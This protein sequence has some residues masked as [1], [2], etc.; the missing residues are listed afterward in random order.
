MRIDVKDVFLH[1]NRQHQAF[2]GGLPGTVPAG[3]PTRSPN[4][5]IPPKM[6][7][8]SLDL[9][10][11]GGIAQIGG[12]MSRWGLAP[13]LFGELPNCPG[14]PRPSKSSMFWSGRPQK[15]LRKVNFFSMSFVGPGRLLAPAQDTSAEL[16]PVGRGAAG[17]INPARFRT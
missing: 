17:L 5:A 6:G 9:P 10:I 13:H 2:A 1:L 12:L 3:L 11:L 7:R 8:S 4:Q 16:A 15:R 14:P